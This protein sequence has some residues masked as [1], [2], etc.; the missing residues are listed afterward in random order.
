MSPALLRSAVLAVGGLFALSACGLDP[1]SLPLPGGP[2]LGDDPKELTIEFRDAMDL[3]KQGAVRV[4]DVAVGRITDIELKDWIALVTVKVNRDVDL[5]ANATATI[6]QTS[7]LGEKFVSVERPDKPQG[8][9][10]SG[11]TIPLERT[12]RN[13]DLEEV[14]GAASLLFNGGGL[15]KTNTIVKE[16]N[17]ALEGNEPQVKELLRTADRFLAQLDANKG[18]ILTTLE[19]VNRLTAS[20]NSE[21]DSIDA[22]LANLPGAL[23]V[24]DDQ[25]DDLVSMLTALDQLGKS[26]TG[27]VEA[28]K[29]DLIANL[30]SLEPILHYLTAASDSLPG[31]VSTLLTFPF[32][33]SIVGGDVPTAGAPCGDWMPDRVAESP[34]SCWGDWYNLVVD[35]TLG[36]EQLCS[37]FSVCLP[38]LTPTAAAA[39]P[40]AASSSAPA[41]AGVGD[42]VNLLAGLVPQLTPPG[43][44]P[45]PST[46]GPSAAAPS[47]NPLCALLGLCRA[48]AQSQPSNNLAAEFGLEVGR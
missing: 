6:R 12:G 19:Q 1:Y 36:P 13:P 28:M 3:T 42:L 30:Q 7:L 37:A 48:A 5:P 38:G 43:T 32:P 11:A 2:S 21:K 33:D 16:V 22:A 26:S 23:R 41:A 10:A 39:A 9:L 27:V 44:A 14:L 25:R 46:T 24:L 35:L 17:K 15:E 29:A 45:A 4:D 18:Q 8:V 40:D 31:N 34:T 20:V 47:D